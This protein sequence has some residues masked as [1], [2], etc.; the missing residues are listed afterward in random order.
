[1]FGIL[2]GIVGLIYP[3]VYNRNFIARKLAEGYTLQTITDATGV[4]STVDSDLVTTHGLAAMDPFPFQGEEKNNML[5][6]VA[7]AVVFIV[8]GLIYKA[9]KGH[10]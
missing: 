2:A 8:V 3:I 1:M 10:W 4:T 7:T 9:A 5:R 6:V